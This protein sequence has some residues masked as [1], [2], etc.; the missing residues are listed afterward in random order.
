MNTES[1]Q[2]QFVKRKVRQ[3]FAFSLVSL[4]L[5]FSFAL[6]WTAMGS[7]LRER[8]GDSHITGSLVVFVSLIVLFILLELIF[9]RLARKQ[10][11]SHRQS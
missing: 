4:I 5:Y 2:R 1:S 7:G 9:I 8:I 11:A 10:E 3:R 6:N